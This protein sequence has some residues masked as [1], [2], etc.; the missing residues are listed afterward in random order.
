MKSACKINY[1]SRQLEDAKAMLERDTALSQIA[2]ILKES[3]DSNDVADA[4]ESAINLGLDKNDPMVAAAR[5]RIAETAANV[6]RAQDV[7]V[8]FCI[9]IYRITDHFK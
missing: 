1:T 9:Y 5:A 6:E 8:G 4:I 3:N 2:H 7:S